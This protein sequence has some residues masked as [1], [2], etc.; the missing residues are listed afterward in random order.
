M[1]KLKK[2]IICVL[3]NDFP[4]AYGGLGI[5][6]GELYRHLKRDYR[7]LIMVKKHRND[8][9]LV[10]DGMW[11]TKFKDPEALLLYLKAF[12]IKLIH[13]HTIDQ[14]TLRNGVALKLKKLLS[15]PMI[16]TCHSL[17]AHELEILEKYDI[18]R[19]ADTVVQKEILQNSD[20]II[21]LSDASK[22]MLLK[23]YP[24]YKQKTV[25]LPNCVSDGLS[26]KMRRKKLRNV[27]FAG[28]LVEEK[29]VIELALA[30]SSLLKDSNLK[31]HVFGQDFSHDKKI[32]TKMKRI[33]TDVKRKVRFHGWKDRK[34]MLDFLGRKDLLILPSYH[35]TF[36]FVL[37]EA[38]ALGVP[39]VCS[40][41]PNLKEL[42]IEKGLAVP[43]LP[44]DP[45]SIESAVRFCIE[46]PDKI[47][48]MANKAQAE[49][50]DNYSW[51]RITEKYKNLYN[52]MIFK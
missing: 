2:P 32:E 16:Y 8:D 22:K 48:D 43:I 35:E 28:R 9:Y 42:F 1:S 18:V 27:V 17:L 21:V 6:V 47:N 7:L 23:H 50:K 15:I 31:L 5:H 14:G 19:D 38:M 12:D 11:G 3:T 41:I 33:L 26:K 45:K 10:L 4:P 52:S 30:F 40:D 49:I 36:P 46:N 13:N 39:V 29:G 25:V 24:K 37:L 44:K 51:A 34:K 20:K